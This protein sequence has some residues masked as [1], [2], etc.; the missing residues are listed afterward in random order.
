MQT[1]AMVLGIIG[2]VA[3]LI[4][5]GAAIY[6]IVIS[7]RALSFEKGKYDESKKLEMRVALRHEL[8]IEPADEGEE[9]I[10][11]ISIVTM[12]A[13]NEGSVPVRLTQ[14]WLELGPDRTGWP[15]MSEYFAPCD[16]LVVEP[17]DSQRVVCK[18]A[19][20]AQW[21]NDKLGLS[22]IVEINGYFYDSFRRVYRNVEP[23]EIN[24]DM[25]WK[26]G[27]VKEDPLTKA[28]LMT[29]PEDGAQC[30]VVPGSP[31]VLKKVPGSDEV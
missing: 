22:G 14:A 1:W 30:I 10:K 29:C 9:G 17:N 16:Y 8:Q 31:V 7:H 20:L 28:R 4:A 23:M 25:F 2:T 27:V 11:L 21:M 15:V 3:G 24:I 6:S 26:D 18:C 12:T 5:G 13:F 19:T